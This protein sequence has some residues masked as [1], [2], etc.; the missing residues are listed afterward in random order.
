MLGEINFFSDTE[1]FFNFLVERA[2]AE[3]S[4]LSLLG[5]LAASQQPAAPAAAGPWIPSRYPETLPSE[6][7]DK[8]ANLLQ[9]VWQESCEPATCKGHAH[10]EPVHSP[11]RNARQSMSFV[12]PTRLP[13]FSSLSKARRMKHRRYGAEQLGL[14]DPTLAKPPAYSFFPQHSETIL[15]SRKAAEH[16][17]SL[18]HAQ[19]EPR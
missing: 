14:N 17:A 9:R 19:A 11:R 7:S 4:D 12:L 16:A 10:T 1:D 3:D 8:R 15:S 5:R 2:I 18:S 13:R 6:V